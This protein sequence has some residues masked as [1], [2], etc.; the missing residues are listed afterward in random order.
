MTDT[1]FALATAHGRAGVAVIRVSGPECKKLCGRLLK[2]DWDQ[3]AHR[4][5]TMNLLTDPSSDTVI[6]DI[7]SLS[8]QAPHSFTGEDVLELQCHGSLGI[9]SWVLD[10]LSTQDGLREAF[11]GEFSRRAL[12]NGK[13]SV[14]EAEQ[15][16]DVLRADNQFIASI[17]RKISGSKLEQDVVSWRKDLMVALAKVEAQIDF[18]DE[19][20]VDSSLDF[21]PEIKAIENKLV[22]ALEAGQWFE[23]HREGYLIVIAGLPNVGKSS[24]INA[25]VGRDLAIVSDQAGT[26]R[27]T[28]E[29][30][31]TIDGIPL[32]LVDTAGI[33]ETNDSIEAL[34]VERAREVMESADIILSLSDGRG[35]LELPADF[36]GEVLEFETKADLRTA[37]EVSAAQIS[38]VSDQGLT[39]VKQALSGCLQ[40]LVALKPIVPGLST[41][42]QRKLAE[43]VLTELRAIDA[44]TPLELASDE[45]K[46]CISG[47][48][49]L[50]GHY[51]VEQMLDELFAGFCIGK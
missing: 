25:L 29:A 26:T 9:V 34:G 6:D 7:L 21:M 18:V 17:T 8:F 22:S 36:G 37:V 38:L 51:D 5:A 49:V 44:D 45:L 31:M 33:R 46:S 28:L 30:R 14:L 4:H 15:L 23:S 50:C 41:A 47:L 20:D 48:A 10:V 3:R 39:N 13:M 2:Q 42:R 32:R 1:I 43:S 40:R 11:P 19:G 12:E 16:R 27:D 24:L 35:F